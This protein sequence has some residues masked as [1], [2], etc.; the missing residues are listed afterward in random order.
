MKKIIYLLLGFISFGLLFTNCNDDDKD[1]KAV[2]ITIKNATNISGDIF[3]IN[4]T[5][6]TPLQLD[7]FIMPKSAA[8]SKVSYRIEGTSTGA[9]TISENGLVT[10]QSKTPPTGSI[11][12][13]LGCDTIIVTVEDGS[14][15]FVRY[16]VRVISSTV[17]VSSIT[18]QSAGQTPEVESG[19]TFNLS[20]YVTINP[21]NA[22]DRSITYVSKDESIAKV[23]QN[24]L[25]TVVGKSGDRTEITITANDRGKQSATCILTIAKESPLYMA[26]P[27]SDK[28]KLS[29]NLGVKEG[30]LENLL[31]DKNSTFWA[32]EINT[33]PV[34][35]PECWLDIDLGD[36]IKFGQLGYRHR[37]L[38]YAH[39]QLHSFKLLVKK[40]AADEWTDLGTL[41]TEAKMVDN[42]QLFKTVPTEARYIRLHFIKGHLRDGKPDWNYSEAGNVSVGDIQVFVYNR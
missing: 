32:P 40:A 9:I 13:P 38:N 34:Y 14:G 6:D 30:A 35:D 37:S 21:A 4:V 24:G 28:W 26:Y 8:G 22:T 2:N 19:K 18:L 11:P 3:A 25:V 7:A 33:R 39:L 12:E 29:C 15:T 17:L 16:P 36:V 1:G 23:D 20:Q 5:E 41:E 42:Y 10:P 31:D 27:V